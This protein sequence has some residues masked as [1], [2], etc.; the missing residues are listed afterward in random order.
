MNFGQPITRIGRGIIA[1]VGRHRARLASAAR[2]TFGH[3]RSRTSLEQ[4]SE[5]A[6]EPYSLQDVPILARGIMVHRQGDDGYLKPD[7]TSDALLLNKT[8]LALWWLCDGAKKVKDILAMLAWLFQEEEESLQADVLKTLRKFEAF[9]VMQRSGPDATARQKTRVSSRTKPR[10]FG[11]GWPFAP[12]TSSNSSRRPKNFDWT[13][14]RDQATVP[15]TVCIGHGIPDSLEIPGP[16][17]AW[18]VESPAI[19]KIQRIPEFI[20]K[21]L[22]RML[23]SFEIILSPD[24]SFCSLDP[25]IQYHPAGSNLPWI[26]KR[27]YRIYPKSKLCSMLAS[28]KLMVEGHRIRHEYA[29]KFKDHLD[30]FGGACGSPRIGSRTNALPDKGPGLMPYMFS[31][32]M[33]NCQESLYYTEKLTDCFVTGTV[34]VYWG[35][36]DIGEIFDERG[37]IILDKKFDI[38]S[39][40]EKLYKDLTPHIK[41]NFRIAKNLESSDDILFE[42]YIKR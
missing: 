37:I 36:E 4:L 25:K 39:L 42:K 29:Q 23:E 32:T 24:R 16:K 12:G 34:P 17:I 7:T 27:D 30:L 9:G 35:S 28:D 3:Y 11:V 15:V 33:E 22:D 21:N 8:A 38:G 14:D 10:V 40:N 19:S 6:V 26:P 5:S 41:E 13:N 20:E 18:M 1:R 2:N 31:I